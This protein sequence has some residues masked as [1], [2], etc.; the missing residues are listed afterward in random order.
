MY[1]TIL[2]G[3]GRFHD[4]V[5]RAHRLGRSGDRDH[6]ALHLGGFGL[7][8]LGVVSAAVAGFIANAAALAWLLSIWI[9]ATTR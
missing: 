5:L 2:R 1:A 3:T 6:A 7:P 9:G 4:A 8:K